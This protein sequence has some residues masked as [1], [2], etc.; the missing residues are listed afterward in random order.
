MKRVWKSDCWKVTKI[1]RHSLPNCNCGKV[2]EE[3]VSENYSAALM[4]Y[5]GT[6]RGEVKVCLHLFVR[7]FLEE[8]CIPQTAA[9]W[10]HWKVRLHTNTLTFS[11]R[12]N[13]N[14]CAIYLN[15]KF[16]HWHLTVQSLFARKQSQVDGRTRACSLIMWMHLWHSQNKDVCSL[17]LKIIFFFEVYFPVVIIALHNL[18]CWFIFSVIATL[19]FIKQTVIKPKE[20]SGIKQDIWS[21]LHSSA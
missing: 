2:S 16:I 19:L 7:P 12:P 18:S 4:E 5:T 21:L 17:F 6:L 9:D 8:V 11:L 13:K 14:V 10:L 3:G 1:G 20:V 15:Y